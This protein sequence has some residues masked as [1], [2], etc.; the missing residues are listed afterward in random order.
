MFFFFFFFLFFDES[1]WLENIESN[2]KIIR[3]FKLD[4]STT[5]FFFRLL[6]LF[7]VIR[8]GFLF[9]YL[10]G[11]G[12]WEESSSL[13]LWNL[14]SLIIH[15]DSESK[16]KL[17]FSFACKTHLTLSLIIFIFIIITFSWILD[18]W[19]GASIRILKMKVGKNSYGYE[20]FYPIR[21][22]S[23]LLLCLF[24]RFYLINSILFFRQF[25]I[26]WREWREKDMLIET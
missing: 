5:V 21:C 10:I 7:I 4:N 17:F 16:K 1:D 12:K 2:T 25:W 20:I 24:S 8:Q 6:I 22:H 15:S 11:G 14:T 3:I 13:E 23:F 9:W 19:R 26:Q 18:L